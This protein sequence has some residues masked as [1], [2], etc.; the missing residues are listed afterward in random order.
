MYQNSSG[1]K[2]IFESHC[3]HPPQHEGMHAHACTPARSHA[4][5]RARRHTN[6]HAQIAQSTSSGI[7]NACGILNLLHVVSMAF[8]MRKVPSVRKRA[9][10][11]RTRQR[12]KLTAINHCWSGGWPSSSWI[13]GL[14]RN[15]SK[16]T[17]GKNQQAHLQYHKLHCMMGK[18]VHMILSNSSAGSD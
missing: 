13:N 8:S 1:S 14:K 5:A 4:H 10:Q 6:T 17:H 15:V 7:C 3:E 9:P 11:A 18:L 2:S 16:H 12:T